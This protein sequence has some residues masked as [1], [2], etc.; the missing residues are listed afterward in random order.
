MKISI[1]NKKISVYRVIRIIILL[2][3]ML[4]ASPPPSFSEDAKNGNNAIEKDFS[5]KLQVIQILAEQGI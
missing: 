3:F 1:I 5:S 2:S 4:L